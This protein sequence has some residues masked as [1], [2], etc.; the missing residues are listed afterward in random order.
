MIIDIELE[1]LEQSFD[2]SLDE[3]LAIEGG[4]AI[5]CDE[6]DGEYEITPSQELQNLATNGKLMAKDL[7]I[8]PI[9]QEYGRVSYNQNK[10]LRIE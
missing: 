4:G 10:I 1:E 8:K 5:D 6:Y 7:I 3:N 9:P 2:L